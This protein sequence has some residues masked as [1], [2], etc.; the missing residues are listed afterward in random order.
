MGAR[1][2]VPPRRMSMRAGRSYSWRREE[3]ARVRFG[4]PMASL[5]RTGDLL[6]FPP[7]A[8]RNRTCS[9]FSRRRLSRLSNRSPV[10]PDGT[11]VRGAH[12]SYLVLSPKTS[13]VHWAAKE[14]LGEIFAAD[15]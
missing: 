2:L 10:L 15:A 9:T 6:P 5:S 1:T 7:S 11:C 14:I 12:A 13:F 8:A 3:V 4:R